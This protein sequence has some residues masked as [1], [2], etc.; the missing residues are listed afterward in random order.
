MHLPNLLS[1]LSLAGAAMAASNATLMAKQ[2]RRQAAAVSPDCAIAERVFGTFWTSQTN[3]A[4]DDC[5]AWRA[6]MTCDAGNPR[7]IQSFN[8]DVEQSHLNKPLSTE[9]GLFT[10]VTQIALPHNGITGSIPTEIGLLKK[11][12]VLDLSA[13]SI[14]GNIPTEIGALTLL[15][16]L[17]L[18]NNVDLTGPIPTQIA[19]FK[20]LEMLELANCSLTGSFPPDILNI[21]SLAYWGV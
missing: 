12:A 7:R 13:N 18:N 20:S 17:Y 14:S 1:A 6:F 21:K 15:T 5:C 11:L 3:T 19:N 9:I 4:G 2:E 10:E 8:F 16:N